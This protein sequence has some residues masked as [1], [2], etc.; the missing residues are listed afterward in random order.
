MSKKNQSKRAVEQGAEH[1]QKN[2]AYETRTTMS[3]AD[4]NRQK[5]RS[6]LQTRGG[7]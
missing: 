4:R 2:D 7:V 5:E 1:V 6:E 3:E